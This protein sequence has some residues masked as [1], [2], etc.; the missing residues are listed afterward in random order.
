MVQTSERS[1]GVHWGDGTRY[2]RCTWKHYDES[3]IVV[4]EWTYDGD[5]MVIDDRDFGEHKGA[6]I[7][8]GWLH[9]MGANL[10]CLDRAQ[11][12]IY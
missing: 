2:P 12:V 10:H 4:K 9:G 7:I 6:R 5:N 1:H 3:G 8:S 11:K